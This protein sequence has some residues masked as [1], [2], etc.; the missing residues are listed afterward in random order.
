LEH[1]V[2]ETMHL[3]RP[4][5]EFWA[6]TERD[7]T[8]CLL[9]T[10]AQ[11]GRPP[12]LYGKWYD[13][14]RTLVASRVAY[15]LHYGVDPGEQHVLHRCDTP[16][17]CDGP[18]LFLGD[19]AVNAADR[20]AKGRNGVRPSRRLTSQQ[21]ADILA[22]GES[23]AALARQHGVSAPYVSRIRRGERLQRLLQEV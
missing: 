3:T 18:H 13:D 7:S 12:K 15:L 22:S 9:W 14:G 17:C 19:H 20:A 1:D 5:E 23:H 16:L 6:W 10:G 2:P 4:P 21:L 11:R 8:G